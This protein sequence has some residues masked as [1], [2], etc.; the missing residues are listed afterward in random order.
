M[1]VSLLLVQL[2]KIA[3]IALFL[4][5]IMTDYFMTLMGMVQQVQERSQTLVTESLLTTAIF[6]LLPNVDNLTIEITS[7]SD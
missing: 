1:Q 3:T 5:L 2:R 6:K 4:I 7:V